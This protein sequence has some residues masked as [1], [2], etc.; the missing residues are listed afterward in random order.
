MR[1]DGRNQPV[2]AVSVLAL[3]PPCRYLRHRTWLLDF[4][5]LNLSRRV[6]RGDLLQT[7][8]GETDI[9][10]SHGR[11]VWY[12]LM[13]TDMES[14]KAFYAQVVGWGTQDV[15][16]P[17]IPYTL[18]TIGGVTVGG[19]TN[20]P[21][22]ERK[23][24]GKP[25][26][27]GHVG[28]DDVDAITDRVKHLGGTVQ[29]P[30]QDIANISRF[31]IVA[32]PQM[33][34]LAV[35]K[36]LSPGR[37]QPADL[38]AP[39]RVGWHELLAADGARAS[40]FYGDLFGWQRADDNVDEAGAYRVFSAGGQT[41]GAIF[42]KPPSVATPFWLYYFNIGD[43]DAAVKR[44]TANGG[45]I[46]NGPIEVLHG[47][48]SVQCTDPQ[49]AIFALVGTRSHNGIGYFERAASRESSAARF[50]LRRPPV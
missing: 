36:W 9:V 28:V 3:S 41:V 6:R 47:G 17:G 22:D 35:F 25:S 10:N 16:T 15:S 29:V 8:T 19:L 1:F 38:E 50:G 4:W 23:M 21:E 14:A 2:V 26:W 27:I 42:T 12:E 20:L 7:R 46:V 11:F 24:G 5:P 30:P 40:V 39:G 37:R 34:T 31:S 48:W 45:D 13:T 43:I 44:V 18:F 49:G 33:A 32:D